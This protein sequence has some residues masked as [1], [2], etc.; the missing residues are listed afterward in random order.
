MHRGL[1]LRSS[2]SHLRSL[3]DLLLVQGGWLLMMVRLLGGRTLIL[4]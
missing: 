1:I 3:V 4:D 2:G